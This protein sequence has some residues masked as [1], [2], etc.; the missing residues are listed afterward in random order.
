MEES[1]EEARREQQIIGDDDP[2]GCHGGDDDVNSYGG[3]GDDDGDGGQ[4]RAADHR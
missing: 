2:I 3:N 1:R 4:E